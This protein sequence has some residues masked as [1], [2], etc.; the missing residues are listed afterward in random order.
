MLPEPT[1][2]RMRVDPS[3]VTALKRQLFDSGELNRCLE[4][5]NSTLSACLVILALTAIILL[6]TVICSLIRK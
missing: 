1:I 2:A 6:I 4:R 5:Q 3:E